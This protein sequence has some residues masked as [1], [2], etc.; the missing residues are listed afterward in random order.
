MTQIG[1][2]LFNKMPFVGSDIEGV[3]WGG[4]A[5]KLWRTSK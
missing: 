4:R 3:F 5:R 2:K 1:L